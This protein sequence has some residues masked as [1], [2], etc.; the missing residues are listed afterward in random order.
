[1]ATTTRRTDRKRDGPVSAPRR[2]GRTGLP[3]LLAQPGDRIHEGP[4]RVVD[5]LRGSAA[6]KRHAHGRQGEFARQAQ[7]QQHRRRI[8]FPAGAGRAG[9]HGQGRHGGQQTARRYPLETET[10]RPRQRRSGSPSRR[11][12]GSRSRTHAKSRAASSR[13]RSPSAPISAR[14][15]HASPM[16]IPGT[17][18]LPARRPRS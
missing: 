3:P 7:R 4:R 14:A 1:M 13:N 16:M 15:R 17:F 10:E 9:R 18:R 5:L 6:A 8:P 12:P 11:T 2:A